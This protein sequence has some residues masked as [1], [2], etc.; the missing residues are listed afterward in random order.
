MS[1]S[2]SLA[3][4][5]Y[6]RAIS[7]M[8]YHTGLLWQEFGAFLLAETVLIGFLG[9]ALT[10]TKMSIADNRIVFIGSVLGF[11]LCFPWCATF[12]HNYAYYRLR[13]FQAKRCESVLG[14]TLL[15]E[16][17]AL[18]SG[19]TIHIGDIHL[20]LPALYSGPQKL[21]TKKGASKVTFEP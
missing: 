8:Q 17:Q 19:E 14:M 18:S 15:S 13:V 11:F 7:L 1:K 21:D 20:Q 5:E 10:Q 12:Q 6:E 16:G 9:T 3:N 4:K 2:D